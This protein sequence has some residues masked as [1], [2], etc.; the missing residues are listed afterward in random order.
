[1][2]LMAQKWIAAGVLACVGS[3]ASAATLTFDDLS[4]T[5]F[6]TSVNPYNG[7]EFGCSAGCDTGSW[8]YSDDNSVKDWFKSTPTSVSTQ[9]GLDAQGIPIFGESLP[10]TSVSGPVTFAGA[11]F[12]S[13]S[14]TRGNEAIDPPI[15]INFELY[16]LGL[17]VATSATLT[18]YFDDPATFL[19]SGY[20]GHVDDIRV[21]AY[22]GFFAMDD[23][24]F[25]PEP[26][27][28]ALVLAAMAGM[29][30]TKRRRSGSS[31]S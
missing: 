28:Y 29:L 18:L 16:Y 11:F 24:Q 7:F 27:T 14:G 10:I 8:F 6:F 15:D 17:H 31:L 9:F 5:A 26:G 1:M 22:Q 23:F 2:K 4:G 3:M 21:Q 13:G 30:A 19:P 25:V 12:T 20:T